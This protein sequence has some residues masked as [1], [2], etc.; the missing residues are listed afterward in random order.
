[1]TLQDRL[2]KELLL[3]NLFTLTTNRRIKEVIKLKQ[4]FIDFIDKNEDTRSDVELRDGLRVVKLC[5]GEARRTDFS[6][7]CKMA[8]PMINRLMALETWNARDLEFGAVCI[9]YTKTVKQAEFFYRKSLK[10]LEKYKPE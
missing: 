5:E 9:L 7:L 3:E 8:E 2:I 6:K 4:S 10:E 1:M